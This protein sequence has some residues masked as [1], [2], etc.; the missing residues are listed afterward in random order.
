M[1][2]LFSA[3][4]FTGNSSFEYPLCLF[5]VK[6]K[7]NLLRWYA[8]CAR[9][10]KKSPS[11]PEPI[12]SGHLPD[13]INIQFILREIRHS[14]RR[15]LL[16]TTALSEIRER[17]KPISLRK[18]ITTSQ[19]SARESEEKKNLHGLRLTEFALVLF[20]FSGRRCP[21]KRLRVQIKF[22][23]YTLLGINLG[24]TS[25]GVFAEV[26]RRRREDARRPTYISDPTNECLYAGGSLPIFFK[27]VSRSVS[28][29]HLSPG[30]CTACLFR[31]FII[32]LS[33][34]WNKKVNKWL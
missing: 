20:G 10:L 3:V 28:S 8:E 21:G 26:R 29:R 2:F 17:P 33:D 34:L 15:H 4:E 14:L 13:R 6:E 5:N 16:N 30:L 7:L 24:E 25:Q 9:Q 19:T 23:R 11:F 27:A 31:N 12:S 32:F 1:S 18:L 22:P